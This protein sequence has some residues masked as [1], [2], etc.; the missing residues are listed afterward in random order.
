MSARH[1]CAVPNAV[2]VRGCCERARNSPSHQIFQLTKSYKL[3]MS[4][5]DKL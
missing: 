2:Y 1:N 5:L 4:M 3:D